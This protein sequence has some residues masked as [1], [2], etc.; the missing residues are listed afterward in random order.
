MNSYKNPNDLI[1]RYL[2]AVRFWMP[3][4]KRQEDLLAEL[5]E[6]LRS[7]VEAR[8]EE[9]GHDLDQAEVSA[10]LKR[11]GAPIVVASRL[12]PQRYV[13]GPALYPVYVFVLKM[14]LLWMMVPIFIFILGPINFAN[15]GNW[16]TAFGITIGNLW[17]ALFI[18]AGIITLVF[19]IIERSATLAGK[20]GKAGSFCSFDPEKLPPLQKQER[21]PTFAQAFAELVFN[22][23][24]FVWL[25]L[26]PHHHWMILGPAAAFLTLAPVWHTLYLPIV[27]LSAAMIVRSAVTLARPQWAWFPLTAQLAQTVVTMLILKYMIDVAGQKP[28]GGWYPFVVL[29]DSVRDLPHYARI[30]AITNSSILIAVICTWFGLCIAGVVQTWKLLMYLR[31]RITRSQ[32]PASL[33]A[34]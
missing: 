22:T 28:A 3:K 7:Q 2:Q 8:Q 30:A 11:C 6:D 32:Q 20:D 16:G 19:A 23:F 25:L 33:Q 5:G 26:V 24:G 29:V 27:L 13:I 17:S 34:L 14:V 4:T 1:E 18:S 9:L 10:I 15:T 12:G 31:K 21:K